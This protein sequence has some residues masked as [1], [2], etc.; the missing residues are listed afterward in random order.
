MIQKVVAS[1]VLMLLHVSAS[2]S[3]F[4]ER[5]AFLDGLRWSKGASF[6]AHL[7]QPVCT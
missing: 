6:R 2:L 1:T 3:V 7:T 4:P 5:V